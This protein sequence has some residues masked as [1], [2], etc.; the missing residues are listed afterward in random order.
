MLIARGGALWLAR[1]AS[2]AESG[3]IS[4]G[5]SNLHPLAELFISVTDTA[6]WVVPFN[7]SKWSETKEGQ[8][9]LTIPSA[10]AQA[11]RDQLS[12]VVT[13]LVRQ[14]RFCDGTLLDAFQRG[15][16]A[17]IADRAEALIWERD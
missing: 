14:D 3:V 2:V 5:F 11:D 17:A 8:A 9:L 16:M 4:L 12:R 1:R 7:W 15:A 6:G 10:M 13:A